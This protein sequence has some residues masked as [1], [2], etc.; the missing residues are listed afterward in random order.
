MGALQL[1]AYADD[2]L[3]RARIDLP[4]GMRLT[5]HLNA[6]DDLSLADVELTALEDGHVVVAGD[7]A[8]PV[9]DI[10]AVHAA[11]AGG[12]PE[13]RIRTRSS[14]IDMVIGPYRVEGYVHGPTAGDPVASLSRRQEM[15]PITS[16]KIAFVLAGE[17]HVRESAMVLRPA[18]KRGSPIYA[19]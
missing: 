8:V 18:A 15:I 17:L 5:D 1:R 14:E 7:L 6:S 19:D 3:I 12:R 10:Y 13:R 11:D 2:C 9:N 4:E 16:A